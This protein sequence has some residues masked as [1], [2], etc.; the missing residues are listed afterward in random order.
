MQKEYKVLH[1]LMQECFLTKVG[2]VDTLSLDHKVFLHFIVK[3]D[4]VNMPR[5]IFSHMIWAL[6]ESQ[7]SNRSSIPYGRLLS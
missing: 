6:K 7:E 3:H 2:G 4:K 1:K 5:Y